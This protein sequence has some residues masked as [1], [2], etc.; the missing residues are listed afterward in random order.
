MSHTG[1]KGHSKLDDPR[2]LK[3]IEAH[4][5]DRIADLPDEI[6]K[7]RSIR[8]G[9]QKRLDAP[10]GD[11]PQHGRRGQ[12]KSPVEA[13]HEETPRKKEGHS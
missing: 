2:G 6:E 9:M 7:Q 4:E 11:Y 10:D 5:A 13:T 1:D 8:S 12:A 3:A